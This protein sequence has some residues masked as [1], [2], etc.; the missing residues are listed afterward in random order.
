MHGISVIQN[1]LLTQE[2]C[3]PDQAPDSMHVLVEEPIRWYP[4]AHVILQWLPTK[5][6]AEHVVDPFWEIGIIEQEET[7]KRRIMF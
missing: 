2:V 1:L 4:G 6:P 5:F 3:L 7:I